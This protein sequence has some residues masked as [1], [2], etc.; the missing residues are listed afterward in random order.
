MTFYIFFWD[1]VCGACRQCGRGIC[2]H[3]QGLPQ[4]REISLFG[5]GTNW[6][7]VMTQMA[8]ISQTSLL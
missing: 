1:A 2:R 8:A 3:Y 6:S 4:R 7:L 5:T